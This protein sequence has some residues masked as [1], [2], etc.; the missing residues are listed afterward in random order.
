MAVSK[1]IVIKV[2]EDQHALLLSAAKVHRLT[3]SNY[4]RKRLDLPEESKGTR[5]DLMEGTRRGPRV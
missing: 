2:T 5:N 4:V 3:L 1:R